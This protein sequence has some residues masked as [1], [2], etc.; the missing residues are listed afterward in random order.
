MSIAATL[1]VTTPNDREI[2]ITREFDAPRKLVF[3]AWAKP[4]FLRRWLLGPPGWSMVECDNDLRT[5]GSFRLKWRAADGMEMAMHGV[6]REV[7][8]PD[9]VVRTESFDFGCDSQ[10]GEQLATIV[11]TEKDGRTTLTLSV[12]YPSKEARDATI[13]SGMER[14]VSASYDRLEQLLGCN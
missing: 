8:P 11:L 12:L 5:G 13:A 14:G 1:K 2:V 10:A 4:E 3:E 6:Y 7:F 9:R